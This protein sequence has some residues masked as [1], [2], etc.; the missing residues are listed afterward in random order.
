MYLLIF[1]LQQEDSVVLVDNLV[2]LLLDEVEMDQQEVFDEVN[3][4]FGARPLLL[5]LL[6][7]RWLRRCVA[8]AVVGPSAPAAAAY[9]RCCWSQTVRFAAVL[10]MRRVHVIALDLN[11]II[12]YSRDAA[13]RQQ[14]GQPLAAEL[15]QLR[16]VSR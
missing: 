7:A 2:V 13:V 1:L 8:R 16:C 9:C 5:L 4:T 12:A 11:F 14:L 3:L 15:S 10:A 6:L